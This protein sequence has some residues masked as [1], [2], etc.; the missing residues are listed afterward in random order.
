MPG[1][2]VAPAKPRGACPLAIGQQE[3]GGK[4]RGMR[5]WG[6][7]RAGVAVLR[8]NGYTGT[9]GKV[10][11]ALAACGGGEAV[12]HRWPEEPAGEGEP[13]AGREE[14]LRDTYWD[15]YCAWA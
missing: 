14:V 7:C 11:D 5:Q 12:K 1:D 2:V 3:R 9:G 13:Y 6:D 10:E 15:A 8:R 4:E